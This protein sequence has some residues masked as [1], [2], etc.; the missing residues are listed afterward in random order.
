[1]IPQLRRSP[2]GGHA[3]PL[4][5]FC[6]ENPMDRGT[7]WATVH[8]VSKSWTRLKWLSTCTHATPILQTL[9]FPFLSSISTIVH[10]GSF[11]FFNICIFGFSPVSP[12]YHVVL[13][14]IF[15]WVSCICFYF[16]DNFFND[17]HFYVES[18]PPSF[19]SFSFFLLL[20]DLNFE[21]YN[22]R[23]F[24]ISLNTFCVYI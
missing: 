6:L 9:F 10:T 13:L 19:I 17:F 3:N 24:S 11:H 15:S 7:W 22:S 23:D 21:T 4:Q 1:M 8:R 2:R 18:N 16:W 14:I 5:Y 20:S 12:N